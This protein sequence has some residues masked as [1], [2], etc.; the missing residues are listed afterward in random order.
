MNDSSTLPLKLTKRG[1]VQLHFKTPLQEITCSPNRNLGKEQLTSLSSCEFIRQGWHILTTGESACPPDDVGGTSDYSE[2][3]MSINSP[4]DV[5][6]EDTLKWIGPDFD[7]YYFDHRFTRARI[8][9]FQRTIGEAR[10]GFYRKQRYY[11]SSAS[12]PLLKQES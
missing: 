12:V 3:L 2:L 7:P 11:K 6:F 5:A 9:D 4:T 8:N 1:S 10:W